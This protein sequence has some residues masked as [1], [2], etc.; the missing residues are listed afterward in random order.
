MIEIDSDNKKSIR[1][2]LAALKGVGLSSMDK[3]V[4]QRE[5]N[6]RYNDDIDY[7]SRLDGDVINKS[8]FEKYS[9]LGFELENNLETIAKFR[10]IQANCKYAEAFQV[11]KM[12]K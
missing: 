6:G 1:F 5:N 8:Q 9:L 11:I 12:V 7:M 4:N 3:L 2:A 10:G